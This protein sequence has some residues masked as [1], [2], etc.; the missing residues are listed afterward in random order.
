MGACHEQGKERRDGGQ[1]RGVDVLIGRTQT[2]FQRVEERVG[3]V[4][5]FCASVR[6]SLHEPGKRTDLCASFELGLQLGKRFHL[7]VRIYRPQY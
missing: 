5:L 1:C 3:L 4:Q 2:A 6:R 7:D